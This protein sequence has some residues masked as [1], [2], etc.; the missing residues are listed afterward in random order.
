MVHKR[1]LRPERLRAVP[2]QFSWLDHRLVRERHLDR[3]STEA[4]ALYLF[5]VTVADAK[6]L[7]YYGDAS[8]C[9][10]LGVSGEQLDAARQVLIDAD[11]IAFEAPLYQVLSLDTGRD[12]LALREHHGV[13]DVPQRP[14]HQNILGPV[15]PG[16]FRNRGAPSCDPALDGRTTAALDPLR[17]I[18]AV[19]LDEGVGDG[20]DEL[21]VPR[22]LALPCKAVL[23]VAPMDS[24][25]SPSRSALGSARPDS[26]W[27]R[28]G[29][30]THVVRRGRSGPVGAPAS[31]RRDSGRQARRVKRS[32]R[33]VAEPVTTAKRRTGREQAGR[34]RYDPH[35]AGDPSGVIREQAVPSVN[36]RYRPDGEGPTTGGEEHAL[37]LESDRSRNAYGAR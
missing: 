26:G 31:G 6:G 9:A 29:R 2:S 8:V 37:V 27:P 34:L 21:G 1:L 30:M 7:S 13:L 23:G 12:T 32:I 28:G 35:C 17:G 10:R 15:D 24:P 19:R 36:R 4:L 3:C 11:L 22:H 25:P 5:L 16:G 18:L 14:K 33:P 20:M